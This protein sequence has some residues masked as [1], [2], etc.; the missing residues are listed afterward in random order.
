M[1][2]WF[3]TIANTYADQCGH[4]LRTPEVGATVDDLIAAFAET[5][6]LTSTEPV[7]TTLGGQPATYM[8]LH[9]G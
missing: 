5:P 6:N 7:Q 8:E 3:G 2:V 4:V 1:F 9:G